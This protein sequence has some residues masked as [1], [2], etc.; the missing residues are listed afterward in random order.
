MVSAACIESGTSIVD[1]DPLGDVRL[2]LERQSNATEGFFRTFAEI[3]AKLEIICLEG[4]EAYPPPTRETFKELARSL[5]YL[6]GLSWTLFDR[7]QRHIVT[8]LR[9]AV[10]ALERRTRH[11]PTSPPVT[12]CVVCRTRLDEVDNLVGFSRLIQ[13]N[14]GP[15]TGLSEGGT[16]VLALRVPLQQVRAASHETV[17]AVI[18]CERTFAWY[19][20]GA[21]LRHGRFRNAGWFL[22]EWLTLVIRRG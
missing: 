11:D 13:I 12:E 16:R 9:R 4:K 5:D 10:R 18:A 17:G 2:W 20:V 19:R 6:E 14:S 21:A 8:N 1:G 15:I 3:A 7:R 22:A